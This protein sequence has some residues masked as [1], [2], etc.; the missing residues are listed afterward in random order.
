ML[1]LLLMYQTLNHL[2]INVKD[3]G[4]LTMQD[5]TLWPIHSL[6]SKMWLHRFV[7]NYVR[8][9]SL[10]ENKV[11]SCLLMRTCIKDDSAA[12]AIRHSG[13]SQLELDESSLEQ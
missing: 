6:H 7:H 11:C 12:C 1:T 13:I 8:I 9:L 3:K 5:Y 10:P 4:R 2:Q